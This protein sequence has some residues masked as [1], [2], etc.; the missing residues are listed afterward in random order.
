MEAPYLVVVTNV[1]QQNIAN[2]S[3]HYRT[4]GGQMINRAHL[5]K[6]LNK[7]VNIAEK[8]DHGH[9][10]A[11]NVKKFQNGHHQ[12]TIQTLIQFPTLLPKTADWTEI[13]KTPAQIILPTWGDPKNL[14]GTTLTKRLRG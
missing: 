14:N 7:V 12:I 11:I 13:V 6:T 10:M 2:E 4:K 8:P 9:H 1:G 5:P 3:L